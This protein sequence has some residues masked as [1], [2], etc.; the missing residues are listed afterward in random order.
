MENKRTSQVKQKQ[1]RSIFGFLA[2]KVYFEN[3]ESNEITTF[4]VASYN[5]Y[6][7]I[8]ATL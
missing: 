4:P 6:S 3:N 8:L 7:Y 2:I 1:Q 5:T